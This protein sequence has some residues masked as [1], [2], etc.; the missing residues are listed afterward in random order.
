MQ[1]E[2][3]N[4]GKEEVR[5]TGRRRRAKWENGENKIKKGIRKRETEHIVIK[6]IDSKKKNTETKVEKTGSRKY[7]MEG[8]GG[9]RKGGRER[10]T[11]GE[12]DCYKISRRDGWR[13]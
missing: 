3:K 9:V 11:G 1:D 4:E 6:N 7:N 2:G 8:L 12:W 5:P 10:E 13:D